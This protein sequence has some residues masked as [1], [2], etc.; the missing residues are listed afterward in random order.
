MID[1]ELM[2]VLLGLTVIAGCIF[3]VWHVEKKSAERFPEDHENGPFG[4]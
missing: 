3:Y 1:N 4:P 2:P